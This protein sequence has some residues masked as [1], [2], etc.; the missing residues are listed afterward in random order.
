MLQVM[1]ARHSQ[2]DSHGTDQDPPEGGG[3]SS[4]LHWLELE[5]ARPTKACS[6]ASSVVG[7]RA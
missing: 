6:P 3:G 5:L 1:A 7:G 4:R 2:R